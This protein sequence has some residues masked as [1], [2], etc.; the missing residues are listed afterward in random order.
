MA[1]ALT[2]ADRTR[3]E[4]ISARL[5]R[6][7]DLQSGDSGPAVRAVESVL[8][9]LGFTPGPDDAQFDGTTRGTL[10]NFQA[11]MGL[12]PSGALDRPTLGAM[13]DAL[14]RMREAPSAIRRGQ[15]SD[16]IAKAEAQLKLLGYDPGSK[17]G[18]SDAKLAKAIAAFKRDQGQRGPG[19]ALSEKGQAALSREAA[20]LRHDV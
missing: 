1:S 6:T 8:S 18:I 3:L 5:Q 9:S 16:E 2:S 11:A 10:K 19:G 12:T 17:D 14:G 15:K 4:R 13:R 7:G 20:G